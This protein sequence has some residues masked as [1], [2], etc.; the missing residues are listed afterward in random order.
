MPALNRVF[1]AIEAVKIGN[2]PIHGVQ[3]VGLNTTYNLEQVFELGQLEIYENIE[4]L[5]NVEMTIEKALDG[6]PLVYTSATST[7]TS[8]SLLA[9]TNEMCNAGLLIYPDSQEYAINNAQAFVAISGLYVNTLEYRFPVQG[10]CTERV[11]LVGNDKMWGT[12]GQTIWGVSSNTASGVFGSDSPTAASGVQRRQHVLIPSCT[13]PSIFDTSADHIQ[14]ITITVNL[15]REDLFELG[16]RKPY[17]RYA[18]FPVRVDTSITLIAAGTDPGD[19]LDALSTQDNLT[20][21][22]IKVVLADGTMVD[23]GTKNKIQSV[24]WNN[25]STGGGV[26]TI[27]YNYT[28]FNIL[29]VTSPS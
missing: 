19:R 13:L 4:N 9:R 25:L 14:D 7:A 18:N 2:T 11:S 8:G 26:A 22:P 29:V 10:N 5:P 15:G 12:A 21:E 28:N 6:Y 3:S 27:T 24:N 1:Y 16:R 20:N 17:Y 23:A